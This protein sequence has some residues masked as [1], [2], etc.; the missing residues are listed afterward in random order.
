MAVAGGDLQPRDGSVPSQ[1]G[2]VVVDV[3]ADPVQGVGVPGLSCGHDQFRRVH[4]SEPEAFVGERYRTQP[5][6]RVR[7]TLL[8]ELTRFLDGSFSPERIARGSRGIEPG[9]L[10]RAQTRR[11]TEI[12]DITVGRAQ[13]ARFAIAVERFEATI[14]QRPDGW[15]AQCAR[16]GDQDFRIPGY[17]IRPEHEFDEHHAIAEQ[18]AFGD[19]R[20]HVS[21]GYRALPGHARLPEARKDIL[22]HCGARVAGEE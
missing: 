15:P 16:T 6:L 8:S 3:A 17:A 14:Q 1:T 10:L 19:R 9:E 7:S 2:F 21:T 22:F 4:W 11:R 20:A 12:E 5:I 13:L 18:P